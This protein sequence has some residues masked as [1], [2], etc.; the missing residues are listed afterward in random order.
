MKLSDIKISY[1]GLWK[2]LAEHKMKKKDLQKLT[3]LSSAVIAKMSKGQSVHLDTLIKV[4]RALKCNLSDIVDL[5][6]MDAFEK[7]RTEERSGEKV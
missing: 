4:C 1:D 6:P 5:C 2:F 3:N 7:R